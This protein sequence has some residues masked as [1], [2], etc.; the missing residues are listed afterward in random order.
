MLNLVEANNGPVTVCIVGL[1][2]NSWL[3]G[4]GGLKVDKEYLKI[5]KVM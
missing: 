3:S 1:L 4:F 2:G 5:N